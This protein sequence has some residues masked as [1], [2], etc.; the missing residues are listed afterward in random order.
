[1][2]ETMQ[3]DALGASDLLRLPEHRLEALAYS[4]SIGPAI[5][6]GPGNELVDRVACGLKPA[7]LKI[8]AD[9]AAYALD[10]GLVVKAVETVAGEA[11]VDLVP[12]PEATG[13]F[14]PDHPGNGESVL[15]A[16]AVTPVAM[17][18]LEA[19]YS[20]SMQAGPE[21]LRGGV[22]LGLALGYSIVDVAAWLLKYE[23]AGSTQGCCG[24]VTS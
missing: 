3:L 17:D 20:A 14:A 5:S 6:R 4:G 16:A 1:M 7:T 15:Y 18:R 13:E 12:W 24:R 22:E 11:M 9:A 19:A 23:A 2:S 8:S 10:L 21:G